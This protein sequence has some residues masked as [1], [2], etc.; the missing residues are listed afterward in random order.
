[1]TIYQSAQAYTQGPRLLILRKY[2]NVFNMHTAVPTSPLAI[3]LDPK[4]N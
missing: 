3:V 4:P 2:F 1:M